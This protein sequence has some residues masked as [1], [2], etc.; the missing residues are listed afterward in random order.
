MSS[1]GTAPG[2][3]GQRQQASSSAAAAA[4]TAA[5]MTN[6]PSSTQ[7]ISSAHNDYIHKISFDTYGR[8]MATCS[9]DRWVRVWDLDDNGRW[10]L[11]AQW[12]AHRGGVTDLSWAHPEFGS[13]IATAGTDLEAKIWEE[14]N[15]SPS[16][17][18]N[19]MSFAVSGSTPTAAGNSPASRWNV[20]ASLTEA[21]KAVT[22]VEFAPRHWGL[23]LA[24]GSADGG[25]RIYEAVDIMNLSQWPLAAT[26]QPFGDTAT[27]GGC[28]SI[29]WCTGRFEPPTLVAAGSHLVVFRYSESARAWQPLLN[30]PSPDRGDVL[31]VAWA[32]N[33][34]RTYHYIASAEGDALLIYKLKREMKEVGDDGGGKKQ[35]HVLTLDSSQTLDAPAWTCN[36]NIT[37]TVL[38][39]S[40]DSGVVDLY[41]SKNDGTFEIVSRINGQPGS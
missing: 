17:T 5:T 41:K 31:D 23:K 21:R 1:A 38:A 34:G 11:G 7:V 22:C 30:L 40:G 24:V 28:T 3:H 9:A 27:D 26:L 8:R 33:V 2:S 16:S 18:S 25:I 29:S 13:I 39:S 15:T 32:P 36:W 10:L 35:Q 37:G 12:L 19:S 14:R 6:T 20:K 4:A